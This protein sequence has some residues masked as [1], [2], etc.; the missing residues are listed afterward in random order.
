MKYFLLLFL[1]NIAILSHEQV[2]NNSQRTEEES[3]EQERHSKSE[4]KA[5]N[6]RGQKKRSNDAAVNS[7]REQLKLTLMKRRQ[8]SVR[9]TP[10]SEETEFIAEKVDELAEIAPESFEFHLYSYLEKPYNFEALDHLRAAEQ[11]SASNYEVL[12]A[13]TAYHFI[14]ESDKMKNYLRRLEAGGYFEPVHRNYARQTL[15]LLPRDA[16]LLTHGHNDT[17]PMIMQQQLKDVRPDIKIL[18]IDFLQS[19]TYRERLKNEGWSV[20]NTTVVNTEFV[21]EFVVANDDKNIFLANSLPGDYIKLFKPSIHPCG[22]SFYVGDGG[23]EDC[24]R[25]NQKLYQRLADEIREGGISNEQQLRLSNS[26]PALFAIRNDYLDNGNT[27]A[28]EKL[29]AVITYIGQQTNQKEK[30]D[31]LLNE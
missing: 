3:V 26:L 6:R 28:L 30:I 1:L 22:L 14:V 11:L 2:I 24:R 8:N 27:A 23:A 4:N 18:N 9:K 31:N 13:W 25:L 7:T 20:P 10:L 21:R 5:L 12:T 29:D 17:Y 16:V 15:K 19:E